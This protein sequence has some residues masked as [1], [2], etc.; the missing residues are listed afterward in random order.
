MAHLL[1]LAAAVLLLFASAFAEEPLPAEIME[2]DKPYG[3]HPRQLID[4]SARPLNQ[5]K[6]AILLVH[7]GSWQAGDK[8]TASTKVKYFL[9]EGFA[10]AALNYR[11]H[12]EVTPREQADDVAGAAVWLAKNADRFR[13]DP[14]Q[15]YLVGHGA[16][17]HLVSLV[18]TDPAFLEKH[19]AKPSDLGGIISLAG[20]VY[21][22]PGEI[23]ATDLTTT[24]GRTLRQVFTGNSAAWP[25]ASPAYLTNRAKPLPPFMVAYAS[26][27]K[28]AYRQAKPFTAQ[29]R[30]AG[31]VAILFEAIGRTEESLFRYFGTAGDPT[32][33]AVINFI[34]RES[35][36]VV[37][38][39]DKRKEVIPDIPWI[40]AFEAGEEDVAGRRM[41]G[42]EITGLVTHEGK[43]F[44]G[45]AH[46]DGAEATPRGQ[47]LRLDAREEAW[48]LEH[49]MPRGY[50]EVTS[51]LPVSFE[52]DHE[53][54]PIE[55]LSYLFAGAGHRREGQRAASASVFIRTPSGNWTKQEIGEAPGAEKAS[56][57]AIAGWRDPKTGLDLVF[58]A[59]GPAPLG[60]TR[61]VFDPSKVGGIRFD[62]EPE[63]QARGQ[64]KVVGFAACGEHLFAAT[65]RQILRRRDGE[66]ASWEVL[67][68]L[69]ELVATRPYLE[70]LDIFWHKNY[71]IG[72]FRCDTARTKTT[73][74]FT[75]LNR[76]FRFSPGDEAPVVE[77]DLGNLVRTQLGR[78]PH[79]VRALD[80]KLIRRKGRDTE[81]WIGLEV[82]YD[83][84]YLVARPNFPYWPTGFGKDAWYLVRTV[85]EGRASYR[86]E[87]IKIPGH[88]PY[89]RPLA[90][91]RDFELSPFEKDNAVYVGGFAPWFEEASD[92]AW[93]ARG[94]M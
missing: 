52:R 7:G 84:D 67:M 70:S 12:P 92:T 87:E 6:P 14:R 18:G 27:E 38:S 39:S 32:T 15:I 72:A 90:R 78:E 89:A 5:L 53:G 65:D 83:P 1:R 46:S 43:L 16:G 37:A 79:Y 56:V 62:A 4:V 58:A 13:I 23:A 77:Q 93:I 82:Y 45:N 59:A 44:A 36:I 51:L 33:D 60:I 40:F 91:V 54:R 66:E 10:V 55:P 31:G 42:A 3:G 69:E 30:K 86:L 41:T 73:L 64:Q 85:V 68:D 80:A 21:D 76:A 81:E 75:T 35:N 88:D 24:E 47:I 9:Q 19:G 2:R 49:Q 48:Q 26:G 22:V 20:K 29:L 71:E 74:A 28:N 34:R 50:G 25:L 57:Q 11:L 17:G 8:R 63:H 61:G 94:E